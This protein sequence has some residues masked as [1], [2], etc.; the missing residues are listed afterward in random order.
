MPPPWQTAIEIPAESLETSA[1]APVHTIDVGLLKQ[2]DKQELTSMGPD[3][4]F[5]AKESILI[6]SETF[7]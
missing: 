5:P 3:A 6:P 4:G 2:P 7:S 1:V